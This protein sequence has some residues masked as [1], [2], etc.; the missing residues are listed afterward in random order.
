M[1]VSAVV[2]L[3]PFY[4]VSIACGLLRFPFAR[5]FVLGLLGRLVHFGVI[6]MAPQLFKG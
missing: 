2:G 4:V 1:L 3:P 5:F 6:V